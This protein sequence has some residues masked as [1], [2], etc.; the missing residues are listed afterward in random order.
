MAAYCR[1]VKLLS[2]Q[3]NS[4]GYAVDNDRLVLQLLTGLNEQFEGISTI[5]QNRDPLPDF[6]EARSRLTMEEKKKHH[7][8]TANANTAATALHVAAAPSASQDSRASQ[9][10][11][12]R[13]NTS[14]PPTNRTRGH[15]RGRH[16]RDSSRPARTNNNT[17]PVFPSS[18]DANPLVAQLAAALQ[19]F[20]APPPCPYPST[21]RPNPTNGTGILGPRP[22]Q[23]YTTSYTPT[24]IDQ[25][26]YTLSL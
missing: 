17:R 8:A 5:L 9:P 20:L 11:R 25:A 13:S 10:T 6:N 16:S 22:A 12:S 14:D 23:A 24:D 21:P 2:D 1:E 26:L 18:W 7:H 3:L 4:I 15:R 19:P